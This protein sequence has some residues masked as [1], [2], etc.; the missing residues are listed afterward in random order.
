MAYKP[1]LIA[2]AKVGL[3]L[4]KEPFLL[5][6]DAFPRLSNAYVWRRRIKKKN[7]HKLLG[8]LRRDVTGLAQ[9]NTTGA[10]TYAD[11]D[12]LNSVRANEAQAQIVPGSVTFRIDPGGANETI[13]RDN[14]TSGTLT[15]VSGTYTISAGT[16]NYFTG[17]VALTFTVAPGVLTTNADLSY[18][19]GLPC[20]G[21][22]VRNLTAINAEQLI[23]FDTIYAYVY[24]NTTSRFNELV[25]GTTW[26]GTDADFFWTENYKIPA[27]TNEYFFVT[28]FDVG[29][30]RDP[31]RYYDGAAWTTF[32][33]TINGAN[34]MHQCKMLF[35]Y[36][37]RLVA[38]HTYE[39]AN[40]GAS[41]A[42]AQRARWSQNGDATDQVNGWRDDIVGRGGYV[43]A[44]T[45]EHIV[46][47]GFLKDTLIVF[48]ERSTWKLRY[49]NNEILPFV[50]ERVN[51]EFGSEGRFS[52]VLFDVG[53]VTVGNRGIVQTDGVNVLRIDS[54]IPDEVFSFHNEQSGPERVHGIRDFD[55]QVVYWTFPNDDENGIFPN[56]TLLYNYRD[57]SFA[58]FKESFTC[59]GYWQSFADLTWALATMTWEEANFP[60]NSQ[61]NQALYPKVVGGNQQGYVQVVQEITANEQS[62]RI[63]AISVA[64]PTV[65]TSTNHNLTSGDYVR[66][67]G[68]I[69]G[70]QFTALSGFIYQVEVV[71]SSTLRL[72]EKP[73]FTITAITQASQAQI[74]AA[75]NNFAVGDLCQVLGV[76][77]MTEIN[78][79]TVRVVS[80]GNTFTVDLDTLGFTAYTTGGRAQNLMAPLQYVNITSG[81]YT[82]FGEM[83]RVDNFSILTKKFNPLLSQG[84]GTR[85]GRMDFYVDSTDEGKFAINLYVDDNDNTPVNPTSADNRESNVIETFEN[86]FETQSQDK[87]WHTLYNDCTG[88]FFQVEATFDE[89]QINS[90]SISSSEVVIHAINVWADRASERLS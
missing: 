28:N 39:G 62:L 11:T 79:K 72:L 6:N 29:A 47:A 49:T 59:F 12:L 67:V 35:N 4:D 71:S 37:D 64:S 55:E 80:A 75:G 85:L 83:E 65:I 31:I 17:A 89:P 74:T 26:T 19:P 45:G 10:G 76:S 9:T 30:T 21:L 5:P 14:V 38:L 87:L 25:A 90:N 13:Y 86:A 3:E 63:E 23:A 40:L 81:S 1:F 70:A 54:I 58:I 43:D 8:R 22:A 15:Y 56:R 34:E 88:S 82:G 68:I 16:I 7:G 61:K 36:R 84:M 66:L 57:Q 41:T 32:A 42:N 2:D 44:P 18:Y 51:P 53:P 73:K 60:W 77:G 27:S 46:S 69:G 20:M 48:F 33:P 50:W 78:G 24:N 52:T